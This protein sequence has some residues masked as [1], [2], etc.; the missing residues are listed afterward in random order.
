MNEHSQDNS[1]ALQPGVLQW[2]RC[3]VIA[4]GVGSGGVLVLPMAVHLVISVANALCWASPTVGA[5]LGTIA[6]GVGVRGGWTLPC[7][8]TAVSVT[9]AWP[10]ALQTGRYHLG[11]PMPRQG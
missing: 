7:V 11:S 9:I 1:G 2:V 4:I 8:S 10:I 6:I 5:H 3:F